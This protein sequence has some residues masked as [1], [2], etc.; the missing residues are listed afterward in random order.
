MAAIAAIGA[1]GG[2]A[3]Q[4]CGGVGRIIEAYRSATTWRETHRTIAPAVARG[5]DRIVEAGAQAITNTQAHLSN[6]CSRI[7]G[8]ALEIAVFGITQYAIS[9]SYPASC[10]DRPD[11]WVCTTNDVIQVVSTG[12]LAGASM[13]A[14]VQM[15]SSSKKDEGSSVPTTSSN[16]SQRAASSSEIINRQNVLLEKYRLKAANR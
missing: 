13:Y 16:R 6:E 7:T 5:V 8:K 11:N 15:L 1:A 2:I 10:K 9:A 12:F 14:V 4:L 3:F